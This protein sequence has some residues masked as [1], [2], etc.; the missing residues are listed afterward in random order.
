[1]WASRLTVDCSLLTRNY[2]RD[3]ICK[4]PACTNNDNYNYCNPVEMK[5]ISLQ[6]API[7][8]DWNSRSN[9]YKDDRKATVFIGQIAENFH[10]RFNQ[11]VLCSKQIKIYP[12]GIYYLSETIVLKGWPIS[13]GVK[14]SIWKFVLKNWK[15]ILLPKCSRVV[16]Q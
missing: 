16:E 1:M 6:I 9:T 5:N 14:F 12:Y 3:I 15:Y 2:L 10:M 11:I 8:L 4:S 7:K 13:N